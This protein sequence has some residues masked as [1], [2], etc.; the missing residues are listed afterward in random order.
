MRRER[1]REYERKCSSLVIPHSTGRGK[2]NKFARLNRRDGGVNGSRRVYARLF[3]FFFAGRGGGGGRKGV[4]KFASVVRSELLLV[5]SEG[6]ATS[7]C[8]ALLQKAG[9]ENWQGHLTHSM[10]AEGS[11]FLRGRIG[12]VSINSAACVLKP[13]RSSANLSFSNLAF[14]PLNVQHE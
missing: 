10:S 3:V 12:A 14:S 1:E 4:Q 9:R 6:C 11:S 5:R 2:K 13:L 8:S 7:S